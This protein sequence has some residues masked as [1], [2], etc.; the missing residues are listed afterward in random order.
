MRAS[1]GG[2]DINDFDGLSGVYVARLFVILFTSH[3]PHLIYCSGL[4]YVTQRH[5]E[6]MGGAGHADVLLPHTDDDHLR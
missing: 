5:C 2:A 4:S 3:L 1:G 6:R